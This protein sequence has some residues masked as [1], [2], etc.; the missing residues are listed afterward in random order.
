MNFQFLKLTDN[1]LRD[2]VLS[3]HS[4]INAS[5]NYHRFWKQVFIIVMCWIYFVFMWYLL[6]CSSYVKIQKNGCCAKKNN[7]CATVCRVLALFLQT[8]SS[9]FIISTVKSRVSYF[10][11]GCK[12]FLPSRYSYS[13]LNA[14]LIDSEFALTHRRW[15]APIL[16]CYTTCDISQKCLYGLSAYDAGNAY[17]QI[18]PY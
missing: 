15:S 3:R 9:Y 11:F 18:C 6:L 13:H 7:N 4:I 12:L 5:L 8:F 14:F 2:P 1:F 16:Y 10:A 17:K